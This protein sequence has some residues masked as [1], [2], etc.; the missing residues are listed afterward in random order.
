MTEA[1]LGSLFEDMKA[2]PSLTAD[3][4][5]EPPNADTPVEM[6][7]ASVPEPSEPA[8]ESPAQESLEPEVGVVGDSVEVPEGGVDLSPRPPVDPDESSTPEAQSGQSAPGTTDD[9]RPGTQEWATALVNKASGFASGAS[10]SDTQPSASDETSEPERP[11][12]EAIELRAMLE[13]RRRAESS[14]LGALTAP[15]TPSETADSVEPFDSATDAVIEE[16]QR[17]FDLTEEQAQ[18]QAEILDLHARQIEEKVIQPLVQRFEERLGRIEQTDEQAKLSE[19]VD[20]NLRIAA[21]AVESTGDPVK[22][23]VM[24]EFFFR[25]E[26]SNLWK[27]FQEGANRYFLASPQS[28]TE[29]VEVVAGRVL[30]KN[31]HAVPSTSPGNETFATVGAAMRHGPSD[32]PTSV[33][34]GDRLTVDEIVRARRGSIP[35]WMTG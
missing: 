31:G 12:R 21:Q 2:S 32:T 9:P 11:S 18:D 14:L 35:E 20:H 28:I 34:D 8:A 26:E 22:G 19:R 7:N 15:E 17:R 13:E 25:K 24:E 33:P 5:P 10:L 6:I 23:K 1:N 3:P 29:A 27:Y 16:I 30:R 4:N